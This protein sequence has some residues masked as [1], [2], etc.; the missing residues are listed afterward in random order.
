LSQGLQSCNSAELLLRRAEPTELCA[1]LIGSSSH[2][3][4]SYDIDQ[5]GTR[6]VTPVPHLQ[7]WR[8]NTPCLSESFEGRESERCPPIHLPRPSSSLVP[9][10][11]SGE[12][13]LL[14][15][16]EWMELDP[17][18]HRAH[19]DSYGIRRVCWLQSSQ[20]WLHR[21]GLPLLDSRC[22]QQWPGVRDELIPFPTYGAKPE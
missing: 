16:E 4:Q 2:W 14:K 6:A 7:A 17:A 3:N 10:L 12:K 19:A 22:R 5:R 9:N 18:M 8:T 13:Q 20:K 21:R 15:T 1:E 11:E